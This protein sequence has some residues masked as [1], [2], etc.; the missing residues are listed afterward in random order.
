MKHPYTCLGNKVVSAESTAKFLSKSQVPIQG[1]PP[2]ALAHLS[3]LV[4]AD[5]CSFRSNINEQ[6]F[7]YIVLPPAPAV[8]VSLGLYKT[9]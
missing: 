8:A 4:G 1:P 2:G 6:P 9:K 3:A 7:T 5:K